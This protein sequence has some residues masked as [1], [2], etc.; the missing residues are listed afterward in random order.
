MKR[1]QR[2]KKHTE[3]I[4]RFHCKPYSKVLV[5]ILKAL[6]EIE[7][8]KERQGLA[9]EQNEFQQSTSPPIRTQFVGSNQDY[10]FKSDLQ[11]AT[12]HGIFQG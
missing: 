11:Y 8:L 3:L 1:Q 12:Y 4:N 5:K 6:S 9:I 10:V 7:A 2:F